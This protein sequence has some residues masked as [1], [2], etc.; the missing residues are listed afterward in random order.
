MG[1]STFMALAVKLLSVHSVT[2]RDSAHTEGT[3][4]DC[5][6]KGRYRV[7]FL[8]FEHVEGVWGRWLSGDRCV[9]LAGVSS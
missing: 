8:L 1:A 5:T 9:T 4:E 6:L 2:K 7:V 3:S